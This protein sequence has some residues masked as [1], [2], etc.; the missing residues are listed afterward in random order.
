MQIRK[1]RFVTILVAALTA[2]AFQ[3]AFAEEAGKASD[4]VKP[5]ITHARMGRI[6]LVVPLTTNDAK[7]QGMKMRNIKNG[8][9]AADAWHGKLHVTVV[10]YAKGVSFLKD[11]DDATKKMIDSLK[12]RGVRFV[13]CNNSLREQGVNFHKL[14][15]VKDAD[16]VPSGFLEVAYLQAHKHYVVDPAM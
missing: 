16:I 15:D 3:S 12:K 13:V 6:N 11:P 2:F 4:Y 5:H 8:L 7:I 10:M 14:Y 1:S 9:D